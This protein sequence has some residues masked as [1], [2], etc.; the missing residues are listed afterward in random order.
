MIQTFTITADS[1]INLKPLIEG[2]LRSEVRLLEIG[3]ERTLEHVRAFEQRYGMSFEEF[4]RAFEAG[5]LADDLDFVEWAG[6]TRTYR[7]LVT[8]QRALREAHLS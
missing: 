8:Q 7:L 5:L 6:E 4:E 1:K 2:A 3:V